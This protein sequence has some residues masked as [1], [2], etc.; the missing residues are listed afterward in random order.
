MHID[1]RILVLRLI[2]RTIGATNIEPDILMKE[3]N[4]FLASGLPIVK[5]Q[6][7]SYQS[8]AVRQLHHE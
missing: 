6:W 5:D 8:C 7:L 1:T 4:L 3:I 2:C